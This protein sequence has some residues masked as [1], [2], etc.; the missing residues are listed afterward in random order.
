MTRSQPD[1]TLRVSRDGI[2]VLFPVSRAAYNWKLKKHGYE[3]TL[4]CQT[5]EL[6]ENDYPPNLEVTIVLPDEPNIEAGV[7]WLNQPAYIDKDPLYNVTNYYEWTHEGFEDFSLHILKVEEVS[8][9]CRLT[10]YISLNSSGDDPTPVSILANFHRDA[11]V[12]R[13]VW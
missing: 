3:F 4:T 5:V 10:G 1:N 13:G 6:P 12:E 9:T 11:S 8:I 2:D 7:E